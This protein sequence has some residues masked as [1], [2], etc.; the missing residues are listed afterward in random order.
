MSQLSDIQLQYLIVIYNLAQTMPGVGVVDIAKTRGVSKATATKMVGVLVDAGLVVR[1]VYGV[2]K[3]YLT[4]TGF[5]KAKRICQKA[6]RLSA[7]I[8]RMGLDLDES[9]LRRVS[10]MLAVSLPEQALELPK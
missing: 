9:E 4:D 7:L 2:R 1:E 10:Y 6:E 3:I 5:L 8:P